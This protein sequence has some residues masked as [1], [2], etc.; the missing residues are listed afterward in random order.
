MVRPVDLPPRDV[1]IPVEVKQEGKKVIVE[2]PFIT[3][4]RFLWLWLVMLVAMIVFL[5]W[6]IKLGGAFSEAPWWSAALTG[7]ATLFCAWWIFKVVPFRQAWKTHHP[8]QL[9]FHVD[10]QIDLP[11][12]SLRGM[13]KADLVSDRTWREIMHAEHAGASQSGWRAPHD[14]PGMREPQDVFLMFEDGGRE[15]LMR[16]DYGRDFAAQVTIGINQGIDAIRKLGTLDQIVR[17][18]LA[19]MGT[20]P[21]DA[22]RRADEVGKRAVQAAKASGSSKVTFD[23]GD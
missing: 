21:Q 17:E 16:S 1:K 12:S 7:L 23:L 4:R 13:K 22:A 14:K 15:V 11:W 20:G 18:D 19:G 2:W 6:T 9:V 8:V 3:G 10:G 5:I